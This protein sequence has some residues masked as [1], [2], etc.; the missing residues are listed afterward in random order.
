MKKIIYILS[1]IAIGLIYS[2]SEKKQKYNN[3][4]S[5]FFFKVPGT[6]IGITTSKVPGAQ[7][8][9]V[10]AKDSVLPSDTVDYIKYETNQSTIL[11]FV[12]DPRNKKAIYILAS[13]DITEI[14]ILNDSLE[15]LREAEFDSL[16][17]E[18]RFRTEPPILKYP[19]IQVNIYPSHYTISMTKYEPVNNYIKE[20]DIY[21]GW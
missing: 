5:N 17:F 11:N 15:I 13:D 10:F 8:Y 9:V 21:G 14:N 18:P 20:S 4:P 12:F 19:Y 16:F 6:D 7:F 3:E 2:C 1:L